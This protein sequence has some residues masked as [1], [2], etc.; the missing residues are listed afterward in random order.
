MHVD[1]Q[2]PPYYSHNPYSPYRNDSPLSAFTIEPSF[3]NEHPHHQQQQQKPPLSAYT[4]RQTPRSK[5]SSSSSSSSVTSSVED[6]SASV[7]PSQGLYES[8]VNDGSLT[9][10]FAGIPPLAPGCELTPKPADDLPWD[11]ADPEWEELAGLF[12]DMDDFSGQDRSSLGA[13]SGGGGGNMMGG[14]AAMYPHQP[15][16]LS[17]QHQH[18][19]TTN[20]VSKQPVYQH[21]MPI[22][23]PVMVS[24]GGYR[25][26]GGNGYGPQ[27]L[28]VP[29]PG[30]QQPIYY[31]LLQGPPRMVHSGQQQ[32]QQ[33]AAAP[34]PSQAPP[35]VFVTQAT[36]VDPSSISAA[37][38]STLSS[39]PLTAPGSAF[40]PATNTFN[41]PYT[42]TTTMKP[43]AFFPPSPAYQNGQPPPGT[44]SYITSPSLGSTRSASLS[45]SPIAHPT[46]HTSQHIRSSPHRPS[47]SPVTGGTNV[48]GG[49]SPNPDT[50]T[51]S[52]PDKPRP[53]QCSYCPKRFSRKQDLKRHETTHLPGVKPFRCFNCGTGFT[54][55]DALHRHL[56][57]KRC[58]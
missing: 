33:S 19:N 9:D 49:E 18:V 29:G 24:N 17:M 58:M 27:G 25:S 10:I 40:R 20:W 41:S 32:Q 36:T 21:K 43:D 46:Q 1:S 31:P 16:P 7:S 37:P 11:P 54:R 4:P 34:P 52:K 57:A 2:Y 28:H 26:V 47:P 39:P 38:Q 55:S 6:S 48:G 12:R 14:A 53:F 13:G 22:A 8:S 50:S 42:T 23:S 51:L 45:T 30:P 56:K 44:I 3:F 5:Q 35:M 15:T